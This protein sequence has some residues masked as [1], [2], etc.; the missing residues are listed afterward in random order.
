MSFVERSAGSSSPEASALGEVLVFFGDVADHAAGV[1][2]GQGERVAAVAC[3]MASLAGLDERERSALFFAARLRN[4]GVFGNRAFAKGDALSARDEMFARWDIPAQSAR[5]CETIAALPK[6]TSDIVRW[7]A[8]CWDGTGYPDQL[9]WAGIPKAAQL[10]QI[11]QRYVSAPDTDEAFSTISA[12]SGRSFA[13]EQTR[14]FST[15]FHANSDQAE[16]TDASLEALAPDGT[17]PQDLITLL[18][19][20]VDKHN[21]TPGRAIRIASR[22][23]AV[24]RA[25]GLDD[26]DVRESAMAS[27]LFGI[28]ELRATSLESAQFDALARLGIE[29]RAAHALRAAALIEQC[30]FTAAAAPI[31]GSRAEWFDGTGAP[32]GLGHGA[33]PI[34]SRILAVSIAFDAIEQSYRS[35]ITEE[36]SLPISRIDSAAG[37]QFD[38][39]C[40][41]AL[42]DVLKAR[43]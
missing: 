4:A 14:A 27:L 41:R 15:W 7:Q 42:A 8:E 36:R 21:G 1:P 11:A 26:A 24:A 5:I 43:A 28:G 10:L 37:T 25:L 20:Y 34:G 16:D 3:D 12:Q 22:C 19:D 38:P 35:R 9:R 40:A 23:E 2:A 17:S 6:Q 29:T 13:P 30:R 31:V 18:A 32:A 33:I 39:A